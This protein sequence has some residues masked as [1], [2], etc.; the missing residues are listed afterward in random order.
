[1]AYTPLQ[2]DPLTELHRWKA[3]PELHQE[4]LQVGDI[5]PDGVIWLA[6]DERLFAY[7]GRQVEQFRFPRSWPEL[8]SAK[9]IHAARNGSLFAL[10][11]NG[12]IRFDRKSGF[13]LI[14]VVS[15]SPEKSTALAELAD[16]S[17]WLGIQEGL[18]RIGS[19]EPQPVD[20][21]FDSIRALEVDAEGNLWIADAENAIGIFAYDPSQTD[22]L[23][24]L[25]RI[26]L[27]E[28]LTGEHAHIYRKPDGTMWLLIIRPAWAVVEFA[29]DRTMQIIPIPIPDGFQSA[30]GFD[31][32]PMPDGR[33]IFTEKSTTAQFHLGQWALL[34]LE[35]YPVATHESFAIALP[36]NQLLIGGSH[37]QR[38][39]IDLSNERWA[40]FLDIIF[41]DEDHT[42]I[43]WF[44]HKNRNILSHD[45]ITGTWTQFASVD[46][47][48]DSPN[49][50]YCASDG[51]VWVTG[52]HGSHAALCYLIDGQW[53]RRE[54][55]AL[56]YTLGHLGIAELSDGRMIFGNGSDAYYDPRPGGVVLSR[57]SHN[58]VDFEILSLPNYP[59]RPY[60]I[61]VWGD[62]GLWIGGRNLHFK[63]GPDS[64]DLVLKERFQRSWIDHM[65]VDADHNLWV[66]N[67]RKGLFRFDGNRWE[68]IRM[69]VG[70]SN[71][72]AAFIL[73]GR[74]HEGIWIANTRGL[75]RYDGQTWSQTVLAD[76][77]RFPKEGVS[78]VES[79]KGDLWINFSYRDWLLNSPVLKKNR[80]HVHRT[81]RY[82]ADR[83]PPTSQFARL[84]DELAEP[85]NAFFSWQGQ[86]RWEDTARNDL[87]FSY[88]LSG[89]EWTPYSKRTE[90]ALLDL[91]H[92]D[93][94]IEVRAR[95]QDFNVQQI[96]LIASFKVIPPIWKRAWFIMLSIAVI[97]LT[98][99][100]ITIIIRQRI[101]YTIA[102]NEFKIDF[103]AN[104]SHELR[105]PLSV[106]LGPIDRLITNS[107]SNDERASLELIKRSA[108]KM[109][110]LVN[111]LLEFRKVELGKLEC[112]PK[113]G[114]IVGFINDAIYSLSPLWEQKQQKME[115][116]LDASPFPCAFDPDK[117]IHITDNLVSNAIKYTPEGGAICVKVHIVKAA[118]KHN[119]L[120]LSVQDNGMGIPESRLKHITEPF[121]T[122]RNGG[123]ENP[124]SGIGL[125]LVKEMVELCKG[126][127]SIE[128]ATWGANKGTSVTVN[129]PLLPVITT[130][131]DPSTTVEDDETEF[132]EVAIS[133]LQNSNKRRILIIEDNPDLRAFLQSELS[134]AYH[135]DT[136]EDG[137]AGI[138]HALKDAPDLIVSDVM[139]PEM[140]GIDL[141]RKVRETPDICHTPI[142]LLTARTGESHYLEGI[143]SGEDEYFNKPVSVP[144]LVARIENLLLSRQR[145]HEVFADQIILEPKKIAVVPAD[146]LFLK[147]A[148]DV[149]EKHMQTEDFAVETFASEMAVSRATLNRKI[150]AITGTSPK[151]FIRSMRMKRAA[152]LLASSDLPI[153]EIFFKV[154]FYDA[155]N[156]SRVFK[157]TYGI[158]PSEYRERQQNHDPAHESQSQQT[159]QPER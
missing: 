33:I 30:I 35:D 93:Y 54:F 152:Q 60:C 94:T 142:I 31:Y 40:T 86:D 42:G 57:Q 14:K 55:P 107:A 27:P 21:G 79:N 138:A 71:I 135:V 147:N 22:P 148:I 69:E 72:Q 133:S 77:F 83:E 25:E 124:G 39:L 121:Y 11:Q 87:E 125:A 146:Q 53:H 127:I 111:Q 37:T 130:Q 7:N 155:S 50:I 84:E 129:L 144:K 15:E 75:H 98:I 59:E 115:I 126:T 38:F 70:R 4:A 110:G 149:A 58:G 26:S 3:Q 61:T 6:S 45:P 134:R 96:P 101:G 16:G 13:E 48:I 47:V 18:Y 105:T 28:E 8:G 150:K 156:F 106:I 120:H 73:Q 88:R 143:E 17:L 41:C 114:E 159:G 64:A 92:G 141:C 82:R 97:S 74:N 20:C 12:L 62:R 90:V 85:G 108:N 128:S 95:D 19:S 136:A 80:A 117:L 56:G 51:T 153:N 66:A 43:E 44:I 137:L 102:M 122:A 123:S 49:A 10:Y 65:I 100:L 103:F 139:M 109:L 113:N 81:I 52:M 112:H 23:L 158:T 34:T 118:G 157:K 76:N 140:N 78:L 91:P 119:T 36:G 145:L 29:Q 63:S 32:C 67:W 1:M 5:D 154:G 89:K 68:E 46:G 9:D 151:A 24:L 2:P 104:L 132:D 116:L 131:T 99:A